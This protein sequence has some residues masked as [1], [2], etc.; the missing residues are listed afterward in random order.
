MSSFSGASDTELIISMK[1][2]NRAAYSEI[3]ER[4]WKR[5][6]NETFKRVKDA[7]RVEELVQDVFIDLWISRE[8]KNIEHLGKYLVVSMRYTVYKDYR[9]TRNVPSFVEPLEHMALSDLDAD[10]LLNIKDI[11]GC[12]AVWLSMQPQ[13]RAEI[14]R[15]KYMEDFSTREIG[16]MLGI[17]QKT[18][19]NQLITS[20]TSLR[21]FLKKIMILLAMI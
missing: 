11:K 1:G 12:I 13:K 5:L 21:D 8:R 4:Y 18:V 15:L 14:F 2:G 3:Y 7:A 17:S 19:Q 20:F 9:R 16:T 10:A 6:Y